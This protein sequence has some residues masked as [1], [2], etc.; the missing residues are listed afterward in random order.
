MAYDHVFYTCPHGNKRCIDHE[1]ELEKV[2]DTYL[3]PDPGIFGKK[4]Y[5]FFKCCGKAMARYKELQRK[6]CKKCG[7]VEVHET[8]SKVALC[9]CCG[10]LVDD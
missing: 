5:W 4:T 3:E 7:R 6:Q 10:R 8:R 1:P 2:G 9:L